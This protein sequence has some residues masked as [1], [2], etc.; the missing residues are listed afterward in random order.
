[1]QRFRASLLPFGPPTLSYGLLS[2]QA[3]N[4]RPT[5][6][7]YCGKN[8][9]DRPVL[10]HKQAY[11]PRRRM[12]HDNGENYKMRS[13]TICIPH[14]I[15]RGDRIRCAGHVACMD[16]SRNTDRVLVQKKLG[17]R[18]HMRA[19]TACRKLLTCVLKKW[20]GTA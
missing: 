3:Q 7:L 6:A 13:F 8:V 18:N 16:T 14:Q 17:E 11:G 9:G 5:C 20:V 4:Y 19:L 15:L 10:G 1:M 12:W 2:E